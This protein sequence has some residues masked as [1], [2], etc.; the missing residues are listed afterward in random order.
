MQ[1]AL[2]AAERETMLL[3]AALKLSYKKDNKNPIITEACLDRQC[4]DDFIEGIAHQVP[5]H[6]VILSLGLRRGSP[7]AWRESTRTNR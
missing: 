4:V 7:G 2:R 5:E 3:A 1:N 6:E